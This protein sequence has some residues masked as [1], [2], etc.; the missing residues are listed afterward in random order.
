MLKP[1][2][3]LVSD[4]HS[5][6]AEEILTVANGHLRVKSGDHESDLRRGDSAYYAADV[7][8]S[9]KNLSNTTAVAYLILRWQ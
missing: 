9:I 5:T 4:A 8:H 6:G 7:P 1:K 3:T 2:G